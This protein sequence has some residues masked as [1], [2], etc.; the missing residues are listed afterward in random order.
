LIRHLRRRF[1]SKGEAAIA[2]I[3]LLPRLRQQ[4]VDAAPRNASVRWAHP[5]TLAALAAFTARRFNLSKRARLSR[6]WRASLRK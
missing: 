1:Q 6:A 2:L 4:V 3:A 5:A